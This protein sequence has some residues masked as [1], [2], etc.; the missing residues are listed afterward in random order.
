[1]PSIR[2]VTAAT[3]I[4]TVEFAFASTES[5]GQ[6]DFFDFP[7][8][9]DGSTV[10]EFVADADRA[11]ETLGALLEVD[12][13]EQ[14][15]QAIALLQGIDQLSFTQEEVPAALRGIGGFGVQLVEGLSCWKRRTGSGEEFATTCMSMIPKAGTSPST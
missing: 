7:L 10:E 8:A 5:I 11:A 14:R 1:M 6:E 2:S 4:C 9:I 12:V 15:A 3:L 13:V